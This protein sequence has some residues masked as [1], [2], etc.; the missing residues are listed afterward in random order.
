MVKIYVVCFIICKMFSYPHLRMSPQYMLTKKRNC[1]PIYHWRS[2]ENKWL[3][4]G[5][6][7]VSDT[8]RTSVK[9]SDSKHNDFPI[10]NAAP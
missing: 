3:S 5:L 7:S 2:V 8:I 9:F 10:H 6:E 4:E 1:I